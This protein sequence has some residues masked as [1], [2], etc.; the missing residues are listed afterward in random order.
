MG[1]AVGTEKQMEELLDFAAKG[2]IS[3]RVEV[4]DFDQV[5]EAIQR[6]KDD[7]ITGRIVVKMPE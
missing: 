4:L 6:L 7:K 3:P 2:Q 1:V 5:P